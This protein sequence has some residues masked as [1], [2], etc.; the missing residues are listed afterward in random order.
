M[1]EKLL[2]LKNEA[3]AIILATD[4]SADLERLRQRFL[5][6]KGILTLLLK[7]IPSLSVSKRQEIGRLG[8]NIK[9]SI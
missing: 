1:E 8:N 6:R 4:N 2:N 9:K 3:L 7:E 5:G